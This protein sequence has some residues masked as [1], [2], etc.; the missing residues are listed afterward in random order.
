MAD[1]DNHGF[2]A[3]SD[4]GMGALPLCLGL[5]LVSPGLTPFQPLAFRTPQF[6]EW[7]GGEKESFPD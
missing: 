1:L 5:T 4:L 3:H 2:L 7:E 6:T